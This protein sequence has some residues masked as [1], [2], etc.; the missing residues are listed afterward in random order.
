M[1]TR[2]ASSCSPPPIFLFTN[3]A[4]FNVY[5][6]T[7]IWESLLRPDFEKKLNIVSRARGVEGWHILFIE[8]PDSGIEKTCAALQKVIKP[9][10]YVNLRSGDRIIFLFK[11]KRF[12]FYAHDF[13]AWKAVKKYAEKIGIPRSDL[14]FPE[15]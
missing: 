15:E 13:G 12:D 4:I 6:G 9:G 8:V 5:K 11:D 1:G 3:A 10:W 2:V 14:I 7:V